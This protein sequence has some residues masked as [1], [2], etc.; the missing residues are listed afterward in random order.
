[1]YMVIS[2]AKSIIVQRM[3][4]G[5]YNVY[6]SLHLPENWAKQEAQLFKSPDFRTHVMTQYFA[7]WS[8]HV[9]DLVRHSDGEFHSW[10]L[11]SLPPDSLSWEHVPGITLLGDAAHLALSNGEGVNC[12]MYDSLQLAEEIETCGMANLDEAV[13][14]YEE[15][16]LPR[17]VEHIEDGNQMQGMFHA[18]DSVVQFKVWAQSMGA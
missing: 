5:S 15:K 1:M 14:R 2:D 10:P 3:G 17:G 13:K 9:T 7:D 8:T 18:Q 12:G 4:N 16:M 6:V 11:Y